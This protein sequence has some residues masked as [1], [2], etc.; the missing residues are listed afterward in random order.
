MLSCCREF[1]VETG[2]ESG[3]YDVTG[4]V[5]GI[6][7]REGLRE[8]LATVFAPGATASITTIEF[9]PGAVED[10]RHTLERTA[11]RTCEKPFPSPHLALCA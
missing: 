11:P 1:F 8:G 5:A 3:V 2:G 10:L 4:E 6:V 7:R 9:E